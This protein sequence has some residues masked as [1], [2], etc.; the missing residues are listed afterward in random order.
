VVF[1]LS[2]GNEGKKQR[3][4]KQEAVVGAGESSCASKTRAWLSRK[5]HLPQRLQKSSTQEIPNKI[6]EETN[7]S[8]HCLQFCRQVRERASVPAF[9]RSKPAIKN[10]VETG[11]RRYRQA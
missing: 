1:E 3:E 7:I 10:S 5:F 6:E 8:R 2:F 11:A 4:A 9:A